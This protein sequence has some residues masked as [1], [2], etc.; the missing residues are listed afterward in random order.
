MAEQGVQKGTLV[1][2]A[3]QCMICARDLPNALPPGAELTVVTI[4]EKTGAMSS[5]IYRSSHTK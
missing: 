5:T 2:G 3:D 4:D 1:M